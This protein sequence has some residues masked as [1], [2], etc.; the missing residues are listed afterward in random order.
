MQF[1]ANAELRPRDEICDAKAF[2]YHQHW[3]VRDAQLFLRPMPDE[4]HPGIVYERRYAASGIVGWGRQ[5]GWDVV[6]TVNK[7]LKWSSRRAHSSA[8]SFVAITGKTSD[9]VTCTPPFFNLVFLVD[10]ILTMLYILD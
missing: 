8:G 1:V 2:L 5:D 6:T 9:C 3:R 4:L 10:L 7:K